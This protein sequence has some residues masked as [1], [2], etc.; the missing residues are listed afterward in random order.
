MLPHCVRVC[1]HRGNDV[2]LAF[3]S[4]IMDAR[5]ERKKKLAAPTI[6]Y[7]QHNLHV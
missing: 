5:R 6:N 2:R 7:R 1:V 3:F 4:H